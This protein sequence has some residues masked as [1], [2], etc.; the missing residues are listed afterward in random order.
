MLSSMSMPKQFQKSM[1]PLELLLKD[2]PTSFVSTTCVKG[3]KS[4]GNRCTF[5][6]CTMGTV[7]ITN[8]R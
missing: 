6:G 4:N 7:G 5:R 2:I 3:T 1:H 8:P